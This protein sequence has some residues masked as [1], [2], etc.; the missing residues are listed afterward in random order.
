MCRLKEGDI[1]R[2]GDR[3]GVMKFGSRMDIFLP[4][5]STLQTR[6]GDKVIAAVTVLA[7][8]PEGRPEDRPLQ[9]T[10]EHPTLVNR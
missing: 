6:V 1:V 4:K 9:T 2:A 3:F 5:Q 8:L 10:S 7:M